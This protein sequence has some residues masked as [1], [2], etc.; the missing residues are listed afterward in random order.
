MPKEMVAKLFLSKDEIAYLY[1]GGVLSIKIKGKEG[2]VSLEISCWEVSE[3]RGTRI[4]F[5]T[6][7]A[8]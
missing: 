1:G 4:R 8:E 7:N 3:Q 2:E 6:I 5:K